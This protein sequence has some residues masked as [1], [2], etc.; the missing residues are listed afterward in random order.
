MS[1]FVELS[2]LL[3]SV[4]CSVPHARTQNVLRFESSDGGPLRVVEDGAARG[5][6]RHVHDLATWVEAYMIMSQVIVDVAPHRS[7]ELL[8]YQGLILEASCRFTPEG[9]LEYDRKFRIKAAAEPSLKWDIIDPNLWQ[10]ATTGR[11]RSACMACGAAHP[12]SANGRCPFRPYQE[13]YQQFC[14]FASNSKGSASPGQ[15]V[16]RNFNAGRCFDPCSRSHICQICRGRHP[17]SHCKGNTTSSGAG[18]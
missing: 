14:G 16:C 2:E 9:W 12:P 11:A 4:S 7:A 15:S 10:L 8:C 18:G 13:S 6:S 3:P 5:K 1:E 17:A